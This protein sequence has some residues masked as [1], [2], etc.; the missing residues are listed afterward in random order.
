[1]H[2]QASLYSPISSTEDH[3]FLEHLRAT[4]LESLD[5]TQGEKALS[6]KAGELGFKN[7]SILR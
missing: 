7:G 3:F 5:I 6:L 1:M 4:E 2:S